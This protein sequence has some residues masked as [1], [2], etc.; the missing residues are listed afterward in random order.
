MTD[1]DQFGERVA[2]ECRPGTSRSLGDARERFEDLLAGRLPGGWAYEPP[3]CDCDGG[4][5][6]SCVFYEPPARRRVAAPRVV[7]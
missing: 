3:P 2:P 7:T 1:S 5:G 4:H 6:R